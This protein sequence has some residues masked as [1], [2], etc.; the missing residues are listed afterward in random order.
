MP[1]LAGSGRRN[2]IRGDGEDR[3]VDARDRRLGGGVH[4]SDLCGSLRGRQPDQFRRVEQGE[5]SLVG[6]VRGV[7]GAL[8]CRRGG[9]GELLVAAVSRGEVG[10]VGA[11]VA[12]GGGQ[13]HRRVG[14]GARGAGTL[15][16]NRCNEITGRYNK[17]SPDASG[18]VFS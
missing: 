10:E 11:L 8:G 7:V 15:H 1:V 3:D 18:E 12:L 17:T 13:R 6:A 2:R 5:S 16:G 9:E 4:R 14:D